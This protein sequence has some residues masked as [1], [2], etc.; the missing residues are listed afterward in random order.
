MRRLPSRL[1]AAAVVIVAAV[2]ACNV[3]L[4]INGGEPGGAGGHGGTG[5]VTPSTSSSTGAGGA[6]TSSSGT[7]GAASSSSSSG[8]GGHGGGAPICDGTGPKGPPGDKTLFAKRTGGGGP[9]DGTAVA[10]AP[11]DDVFWVGTYAS[12]DQAFGIAALPYPTPDADAGGEGDDVYVAKF[13]AAGAHVWSVGFNGALDQRPYAAAADPNGDVVITGSMQGSITFGGA[14]L[15]AVGLDGFVAK[16]SGADGSV[17]WA[18][19]ITGPTDELGE[20]VAITGG[21][22]VIVAGVTN[23]DI[24]LGCGVVSVPADQ[25]VFLARLDQ[26][27]GHCVWS[28]KYTA[29]TRFYDK[30]S[31]GYRVSVAVDTRDDHLYVAGGAAGPNFGMGPATGFGGKDVFLFKGTGD[32]DYVDLRTFGDAADDGLQYATGVAVDPCGDVLLAGGFTH[33]LTFGPTALHAKAPVAADADL[34]DIFVAKLAPDLS[35]LWAVSFGDTGTQVAVGVAT[36]AY[37]NVY[38]GG[39]LTDTA[40]STGVDFGGGALQGLGDDVYTPGSYNDDVF[41]LELDAA[42]TYVWAHRYGTRSG[43]R[44]YAVAASRAGRFA[45]SGGFITDSMPAVVDFGDGTQPLSALYVDGFL[46]VRGP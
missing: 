13:G 35:P 7:G 43:D 19:A 41:G 3:I 46:A 30:D 12:D 37:G 32:G 29:D 15:T 10:F 18:K 27:D 42:G 44:A 45:L 26:N 31:I 17:K 39:N 4:G 16:I 38:V 14:T 6:T 5:G 11:T 36:D 23:G 28:H 20:S 33:S 8:A 22:D 9:E 40:A 21:G 25:G 24:D 2:P 34:E 1:A